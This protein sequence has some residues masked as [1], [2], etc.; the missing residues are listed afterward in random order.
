MAGV[1]YPFKL[2][3]EANTD[4]TRTS[5]TGEKSPPITPA[6]IGVAEAEYDP[7]TCKS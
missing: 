4:S 5:F 1:Q 3:C 6:T 2:N 7:T